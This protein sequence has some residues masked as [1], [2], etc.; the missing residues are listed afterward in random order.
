MKHS[1]NLVFNLSIFWFLSGVF[2][3]NTLSFYMLSFLVLGCFILLA[4]NIYLYT[5]KHSVY[6]ISII[7]GCIVWICL[8]SFFI[9]KIY[10]NENF[11]KPYYYGQ[12]EIQFYIKDIHK[13]KDYSIEYKGKLTQIDQKWV[14]RDIYAIISIPMNFKVEK[15]YT[16]SF[17]SKL[18]KV[19]NF[20]GFNY[21]KYLQSQDIYFKSFVVWLSVLDRD[22]LSIFGNIIY[23]F[24][25]EFLRIIHEIYPK[26]E[27]IFLWWILVWARENLPDDLKEDFNNSWLTHFIAV[28]GFN[29]TILIIFFAY[30]LQFFPPYLRAIII[31]AAII[32]FTLLV[33]DTPPVVR[34]AI[35]GII[36]YFVMISGRSNSS[37]SV[38]LLTCFLMV[39]WSPL[40]LNYDVSFHLSFLAVVWILY[41]QWFFKHIFRFLPEFFAIREAVV[42]T[43]AALSFTLPIMIFNFGQVSFL[44]P[45]ANVLVTWTIPIAML[46][47]FISVIW[48]VIHPSIW[49]FIWFFDWLFLR[50]DMLIVYVF[51]N[52]EFSLIKI[53]FGDYSVYLEA[54]YFIVLIF[55]ILIFQ[56]K[57][58]KQLL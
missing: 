37:L 17:R 47:W 6:I 44:S 25:K 38:I 33:W 8:S 55:L 40:S 2:I 9:Q 29:M 45:I 51:W 46:L 1:K 12:H 39:F 31:T 20:D 22:W 27:A 52:F 21:I 54:I 42:L 19:D 57:K 24:R 35:M 26:R 30:I 49:V 28:S 23:D 15:W 58:T 13:V 11:L 34:A 53:D 18:Y 50:Y 16:L 7:V 41:T 14:D 4:G 36:G 56:S 32:L 10:D 48:Y 5:Q 43:F 3:T